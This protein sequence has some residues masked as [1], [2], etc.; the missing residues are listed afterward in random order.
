MSESAPII[1]W[2]P[3]SRRLLH[4][5]KLLP[6]TL[7]VVCHDQCAVN[8]RPFAN[9]LRWQPVLK[10][11]QWRKTYEDNPRHM[12]FTWEILCELWAYCV[13]SHLR[14]WRWWWRRRWWCLKVMWTY[15]PQIIWASQMWSGNESSWAA[16]H[17]FSTFTF[18]ISTFY[19]IQHLFPFGLEISQR[20]LDILTHVWWE[21]TGNIICVQCDCLGGE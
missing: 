15:C 3:K 7:S 4:F 14:W 18:P 13:Q 21:G 19:L 1:A 9:N 12:Y 17:L 6:I 20:K 11:K 10:D 2:E 16:G 5:V 8:K